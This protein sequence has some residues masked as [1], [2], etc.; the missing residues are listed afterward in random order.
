MD[1]LVQIIGVI[2]II[3]CAISFFFKKKEHFLICLIAYN[4]LV[5]LLYLLQQQVTE[6]I[7]TILG[8]VREFIFFTYEKRNKKPQLAVLITI[9]AV[10]L[11]SGIV[12]FSN[13]YSLLIVLSSLLSTY[14]QWQS[15][16]LVLRILYSICSLLVIANYLCLGFYTSIIA[17]IISLASSITSIFKYHIFGANRQIPMANAD[18]ISST[19]NPESEK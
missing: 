11:I 10:F 17:E 14:A 19:D 13:W 3:I 4:L 6:S 12:T 7:I 5:L 9:E 2:L 15:N 8:I 1:I 18:S 16:M